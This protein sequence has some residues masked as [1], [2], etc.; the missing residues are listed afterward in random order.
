MIIVMNKII[1]N[2]K[3]TT[4]IEL[5]VGMS[6]IAIISGTVLANFRAGE[7]TNNLNVATQK[8][9]SDIRQVQ[10]YAMSLKEHNGGVPVGGWGIYFN[11]LAGNGGRYTIFAD[12]DSDPDDPDHLCR[13]FNQ[14]DSGDDDFFMSID[15]PE[16][17]EVTNL[18]ADMVSRNRLQVSFDPPTPAVYLCGDSDCDNEKIEITLSSIGGSKTIVIN[19]FGL[20][21]VK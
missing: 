21:E 10:N 12:T 20:I 4:L 3:G 13:N 7:R 19:K 16:G 9:V 8:L 14:C 5:I 11:K 17:V 6:I 18:L 1:G 15:L 2:N